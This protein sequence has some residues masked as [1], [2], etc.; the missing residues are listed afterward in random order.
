[1]KKTKSLFDVLKC[2]ISRNDK[3][4]TD[5]L[6][7]GEYNDGIKILDFDPC[8]DMPIADSQW[9]LKGA[10]DGEARFIL[11]DFVE[12]K[13]CCGWSLN[14]QMARLLSE[15]GLLIARR[16]NKIIEETDWSRGVH[17][18]LLAYLAVKHDGAE[19][20]KRLLD[21]VPNDSR[22]GLFL[23]CWKI[24]DRKLQGKL[25]RKFKEWVTADETWGCGDGEGT[26]L[27]Y[28]L[29]KWISEETFT[30]ERLKSLVVW[31]FRHEH[32]FL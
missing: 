22:D 26:W 15:R 31:H 28:F 14:C 12:N 19:W 25:L 4:Y 7:W 18:L 3:E 32:R 1:M 2:V 9:V 27:K 6:Q 16:M 8:S 13:T 10:T 24:E 11:R 30:Y 5:E 29:G 17:T 21:V 23:A 20:A